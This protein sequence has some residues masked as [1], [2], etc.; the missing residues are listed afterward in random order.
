MTI[1]RRVLAAALL[2]CAGGALAATPAG[3]SFTHKDW[4]VDCDNTGTCRA[5]GYQSDSDDSPVSVMLTREAGP[6]A[7]VDAQVQF[8]SL[9][10]DDK[11]G[12]E[13]PVRMTIGGHAAG[14]VVDSQSVSAAQVAALL[15]AF[16]GSGEV[17]FSAGKARWKLSGDGAT[18]VLLKMD[19]VQGRIGTPGALVRKGTKPETAVPGPVKP[20]VI[21]AVRVPASV[22]SDLPLALKILAT[23]KSDDDCLLS[24]ML[25][26]K[27]P[28]KSQVDL[29]HLGGGRVL[30]TSLCW[31]AAYNQ[32]SGFW[33]AKDQPPYDAKA[34]TTAGSGFAPG[35]G[36]ISSGQKGRGIG[37]CWSLSSWVWDGRA[38]VHA[39]ESSTGQCKLVAAGGPWDLP[40]LVSEV[41]KPR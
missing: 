32:G 23:I 11:A 2:A 24:E 19:D 25:D 41:R 4:S 5:S 18:A 37:D 28:E 15:K 1:A 35:T 36:E 13:G 39:A 17:A 7:A 14:T 30:V 16:T 6:N 22:K 26:P 29:W 34:V 20:P 33:V 40:T 38:F 21:Q 3:V 31:N 8:G 27:D 12:P 9:H 10:G